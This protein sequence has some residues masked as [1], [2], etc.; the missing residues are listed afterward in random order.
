LADQPRDPEEKALRQPGPR[1]G[2]ETL[3]LLYVQPENWPPRR[4]LYDWPAGHAEIFLVLRKKKTATESM[5][6]KT[7]L[8]YLIFSSLS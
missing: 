4:R 1:H 2:N 5:L 6:P 7:A 3:K 8:W